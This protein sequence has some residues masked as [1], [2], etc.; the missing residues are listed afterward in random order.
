MDGRGR[1]R[2]CQGVAEGGGH[3]ADQIPAFVYRQTKA[4]AWY[5][6]V[7]TARHWQIVSGQGGRHRGQQ[8]DI[9]LDQLRR[10]PVQVAWRKREARAQ[11]V[12][13]GAHS[14]AE[15]YIH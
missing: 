9:F 1:P 6:V 13:S 10:S 12:R 3:I 14:Q 15:H 4:V 7:R 5:F 8:L 2:Q 11:S